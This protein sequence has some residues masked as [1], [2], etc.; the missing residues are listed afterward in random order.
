MNPAQPEQTAENP[1]DAAQRGY[2]RRLYD[3]T[4]RWAESPYAPW[5]LFALAFAEASFFPIPPDALLIAM[6]VAVPRKSLRYGAICTAGSVVGGCAGYAI[7]MFFFE[8]AAVPLLDFYHA[9][10]AYR[11]I[12]AGFQANGFLYVF[13]SAL[14]PIPYKVFT[15]AAGVCGISLP[16]LIGASVVG[17]G[18]RFMAQGALF[19]AFGPQ[20]KA[21]IERYFNVFTILFLVLLIGGF[22]VVKLLW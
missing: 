7:G 17:R 12:S 8:T 21:F 15:I 9:W 11:S 22:V 5:A 2:M 19:R 3:W 1:D 13:T 16:V 14:T 6:A 10:D 20:I 4:I 18:L